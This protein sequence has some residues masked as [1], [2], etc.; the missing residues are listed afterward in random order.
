MTRLRAYQLDLVKETA[1]ALRKYRSVLLQ[2]PT[3]SGKTQMAC[4]IA[5]EAGNK[6]IWFVCH[7]TEILTNA[8]DA[9]S[10]NGLS[11]HAIMAP[12]Y[13]PDPTKKMQI[14]SIGAVP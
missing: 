14:C 11:D 2:A 4:A 13:K 8:S 6:F 12:G 1:D 10:E 3:A 7:R 5:R 9:F